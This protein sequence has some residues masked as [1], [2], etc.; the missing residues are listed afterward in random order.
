MSCSSG[1][2]WSEALLELGAESKKSRG[3]SW[4]RLLLSGCCS[5]KSSG[6]TAA[7]SSNG[8]RDAVET[9][10][11]RLSEAGSTASSPRSD[12]RNRDHHGG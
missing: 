5:A 9:E 11:S 12:G 10:E 2:D 4:K 1:D 7:A 8:Q 3:L 6:A